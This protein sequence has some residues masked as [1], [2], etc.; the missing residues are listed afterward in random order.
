MDFAVE[1]GSETRE[2]QMA[3]DNV[4]Q[5]RKSGKMG[6]EW[7]AVVQGGQ[8]DIGDVTETRP[9]YERRLDT[10]EPSCQLY[11]KD[12]VKYIE[13]SISMKQKQISQ[14]APVKQTS[15]FASQTPQSGTLRGS[16]QPQQVR[17]QQLQMEK[18]RLRLKHQELLQQAST[19][20]GLL[21][22][23]TFQELALRNQLPILN[24]NC[25]S[26][27]KVTS[28]V[29]SQEMTAVTAN[30]SD[31]FLNSASHHSRDESTDSG[32][33][34]SSYSIPQMPDNFLSSADEMDTGEIVGQN[35]VMSQQNQ[36]Q[37]C[38][39]NS[40]GANV[41]HEVLEEEA[42]NVEGELM[43]SLQDALNSDLL[44]DMESVLAATKI[45]KESFLTWL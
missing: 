16:N 18:E 7:E 31:P 27:T 41:D 39:E 10:Q 35:N 9:S 40:S 34:M 13:G 12:R 2:T 38:A 45:D 11:L 8:L 4:M 26:Q 37:S 42:M 6:G 24:Q 15:A 3:V 23:Q 43:P 5:C 36:F 44:I 22:C 33:S 25:S 32:L 30:S 17:L 19:E 21:P 29:L 20:N 1:S 14:S 28:P